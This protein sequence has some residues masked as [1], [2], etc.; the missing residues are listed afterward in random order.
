[1]AIEAFQEQDLDE[2]QMRKPGFAAEV[3]AVS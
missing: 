2:I 1:M 3:T